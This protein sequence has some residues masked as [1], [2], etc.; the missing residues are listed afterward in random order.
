MVNGRKSVSHFCLWMR[1]Y[2]CSYQNR[3]C[4]FFLVNGEQMSLI[5][6]DREFSNSLLQILS[7]S[8]IC[9]HISSYPLPIKLLHSYFKCEAHMLC[10]EDCNIC[11]TGHVWIDREIDPLI[12][13][14]LKDCNTKGLKYNTIQCMK[15]IT[16]N[17][18]VYENIYCHIILHY[19]K[20]NFQGRDLGE[21]EATLLVRI[22]DLS[23]QNLILVRIDQNWFWPKILY[24]TNI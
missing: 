17:F 1:K 23:D 24:S 5:L 10:Y 3:K 16:Q 15:Y 8:T 13:I 21:E 18:K 9:L 4:L 6:V 2:F 11:F 20:R 19:K 7:L 22:I 12:I 14:S